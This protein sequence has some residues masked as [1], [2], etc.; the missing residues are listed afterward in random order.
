VL[1]VLAVAFIFKTIFS[2]IFSFRLSRFDGFRGSWLSPSFADYSS[3]RAMSGYAAF[4]ASAPLIRQLF[5][6][7]P[8]S[9]ISL[10]PP[11]SRQL[12]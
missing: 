8:L 11:I 1:A 3:L 12:N 4:T 7:R 6:I 10:S 2:I 5:M 9:G